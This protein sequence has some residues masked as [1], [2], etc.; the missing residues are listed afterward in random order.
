MLSHRAAIHVFRSHHR[1]C[2]RR[3]VAAMAGTQAKART[4]LDEVSTTGAFKRFDSVYRNT[5]AIGSRFEPEGLSLHVHS[6]MHGQTDSFL[7]ILNHM[8]LYIRWL[9]SQCVAG[10]HRVCAVTDRCCNLHYS[11]ALPPL[12]QPC[13]PVGQPVPHGDASQ[14]EAPHASHLGPRLQDARWLQAIGA[15]HAQQEGSCAVLTSGSLLHPCHDGHL[16]AGLARRHR[17]V[18][19]APYLAAHTARQ[20]RRRA[21][22]LD[23]CVAAGPSPHQL[24]RCAGGWPGILPSQEPCTCVALRARGRKYAPPASHLQLLLL[25]RP[26][27]AM[28]VWLRAG[29]GS[30]PPTACVPDTVNGAKFVRDLYEMCDPGPGKQ[31]PHLSTGRCRAR[32]AHAHAMMGCAIIFIITACAA[33]W[34]CRLEHGCRAMHAI[35][36]AAGR[37]WRHAC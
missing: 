3:S 4:A 32:S 2:P 9:V 17:R 8:F 26:K 5:I 16:A 28:L 22:R 25:A 14:G 19:R 36:V 30:F 21:L 29:F 6:W 13:M 33:F 15:T 23:L 1:H 31:Q 11:R 37:V 12:H 27:H 34:T 18:R 20:P 35:T 10:G 24:N 7:Q